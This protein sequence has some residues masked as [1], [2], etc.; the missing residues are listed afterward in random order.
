[1]PTRNFTVN[2]TPAGSAASTD[3]PHD[4]AEQLPL[5]R[6]RGRP[7]PL[8]VTFGDGT[9]E[10]RVD[11]IGQTLPDDDLARPLPIVAGSTP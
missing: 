4:V 2:G 8:R 3:G 11:V 5:E 9:A 10:V 6:Q 1:M 7:P